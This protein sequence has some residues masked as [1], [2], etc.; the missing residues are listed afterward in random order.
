MRNQAGRLGALSYS[1]PAPPLSADIRKDYADPGFSV[2]LSSFIS[3]S[4]RE[5]G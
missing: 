3:L 5:L 1:L 2:R 4:V